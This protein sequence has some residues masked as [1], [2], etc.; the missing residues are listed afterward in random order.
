MITPLGGNIYLTFQ[1]IGQSSGVRRGFDV[2][3]GDDPPSITGGYAKW[4]NIAR[5]LQRA[6]VVFQGYDP[7]QMD[8]NVRFGVWDAK[9]GWLRDD[10]DPI[11]GQDVRRVEAD[12]DTLEWMA[13]GNFDDG[14]SP[15]VYV[16][17]H[18]S[19]GRDTDLISGKYHGM[20]WIVTNIQ[21]GKSYRNKNG[22]RT[23]QE[24]TISLTNYLN[25]GRTP[26]PDTNVRGA[27]FVSKPGADT[28]LGIA[29]AWTGR[30]PTVDWQTLAKNIC[31]DDQNNPC[32]GT[33]LNLGRRSIS[34]KIRHGVKVWV[35]RHQGF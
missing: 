25:L 4:T 18:G 17:S 3:V 20:A 35:P 24:A 14:P 31:S 32:Q 9:R 1:G 23:W 27:Y 11:S 7:M 12:I 13:G 30:T 8:V 5:P 10:T 2:M 15:V 29:G 26:A 22:F 33:N 6:L 19:Q 28:P 21:W 34:Y 16:Y